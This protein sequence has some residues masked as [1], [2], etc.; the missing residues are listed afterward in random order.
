MLVFRLYRLDIKQLPGAAKIIVLTA[1]L[2]LFLMYLQWLALQFIA[3]ITWLEIA[4]I[5]NY[6][7]H[8]HPIARLELHL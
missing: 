8:F 7:S 5:T 4:E 6:L 1:N 2:A 3:L